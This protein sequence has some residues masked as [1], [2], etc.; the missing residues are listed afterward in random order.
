MLRNKVVYQYPNAW[1]AIQ[2]QAAQIAYHYTIEEIECLV[3]LMHSL[4][5]DD[6]MYAISYSYLVELLPA[7][8]QS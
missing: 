2:C 3:Q 5:V 1:K 7:V 8:I 6:L 4:M